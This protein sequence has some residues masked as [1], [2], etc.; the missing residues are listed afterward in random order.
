MSAWSGRGEIDLGAAQQCGVLALLLLA[1]GR[2]V[3]L[4]SLIE[5]IWGR[6]A[7][8]AAVGTLRGYIYKLRRA[9][10]ASG[11]EF[12]ISSGRGW[13]GLPIPP[14]ALDLTVFESHVARARVKAASGEP[15]AAST[16][17][18]EALG[19]WRGHALTG[20]HGEFVALERVRLGQERLGALEERIALDL[21]LGRHEEVLTEIYGLV[22][23]APLQERL[24]ELQMVALYRCSRQADALAAYQE[25]SGLLDEELGV[26][27]NAGLRGL[28][29]RILRGDPSLR[30]PA[31]VGHPAPPTPTAPTGT[32]PSTCPAAAPGGSPEDRGGNG[33]LADRLR[34]VRERGFVG[35]HGE[36]ERF[37]SALAGEPSSFAVLFLHG[38]GGVGKSM[39]ARRLAD[40]AERAGRPVVRV[41]GRVLG[42]SV[43]A[44]EDAI[45]PARHTPGMV[46]VIDT[47]ERC[48]ELEPWLRDDL[49][50]GLPTDALVVI[51]G[52]NQPSSSWRADP[53]WTQ[54]LHTEP[55]RDLSQSE[56]AALL[57]AR[58]VPPQLHGCVIDRVGGH[59]LALALAA[60]VTNTGADP[61]SVLDPNRNVI[62]TLLIELVGT[63]PS[64]AHKLALQVCAH[65]R[66]T[67]EELLRKVMP[68][69]DSSSLF[70]WLRGLPYVESGSHGLYP[71]DVVRE[72]LQIDLRWRDPG[73]HDAIERQVRDYVVN[74]LLANRVTPVQAHWLASALHGQ[75]IEVPRS[76]AERAA[77][78]TLE[79]V[80]GPDDMDEMLGL[81]TEVRG[82]HTAQLTE[83]W[84]ARQPDSFRIFRR[85]GTGELL[86][87]AS[88]L[89][90]T[91]P[92]PDE[93][94]IDPV[95]AAAWTQGVAVRPPGPAEHVA[96]VWTVVRPVGQ[97]TDAPAN[98]AH[99]PD[100]SEYGRPLSNLPKEGVEPGLSWS[101]VASLD[102][103]FWQ[104]VMEYLERPRMAGTPVL[105]GQQ[106]GLFARDRRV[107]LPAHR[108]GARLI[109]QP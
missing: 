85:P 108:A 62:E 102:P 101:F 80:P 76:L 5:R 36:R 82:P 52:R 106:I 60:E 70:G 86:A 12:E 109:R 39:L 103:D 87:F 65:V 81:A 29:E 31:M 13:Y 25:V 92:A 48:E 61:A 105:D 74:R 43:A 9:F 67:T 20:A 51:A 96:L 30:T 91:T 72:A 78:P 45:R 88:R 56:A 58:G 107:A 84:L 10:A 104:P 90:I 21:A 41:D 34:A 75:G 64:P 1:R 68:G 50:P 44:F 63:T 28:Y 97:R 16:L 46:L 89:L 95:L 35:R 19:L 53:A 59:P 77:D 99:R 2:P 47:F 57:R 83:F 17:L 55:V 6:S 11:V 32:R 71:H 15:A 49:L 94:E 26:E 42:S 66:N 100:R 3:T 73:S 37:A 40:D 23:S 14:E 93:L 27:P 18:R 24:R 69:E 79:L 33:L 7:P 22:M 8:S 4:E 98:G 54:A 38:P